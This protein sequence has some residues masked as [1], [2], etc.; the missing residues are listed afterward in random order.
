MILTRNKSDL[1]GA[2]ASILCL[3]H[4][5]ATP[6]LFM[7]HAY[8]KGTIGGPP[9]WW[10]W[11]DYVFLFIAFLAVYK[12]ARTTTKNWVKWALWISLAV[13]SLVIFNEKWGWLYAPEALIYFPAIALIFLHLY[14]LKYASCHNEMCHHK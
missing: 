5:A 3:I 10:H 2:L 7:T 12:S 1:F 6:L 9:T 4:C 14:N 13:L 11:I 8:S